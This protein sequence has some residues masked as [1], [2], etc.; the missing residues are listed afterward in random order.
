MRSEPPGRRGLDFWRPARHDRLVAC[1]PSELVALL[2]RFPAACCQAIAM[3]GSAR[4]CKSREQSAPPSWHGLQFPPR[5]AIHHQRPSTSAAVAA[6]LQH[7]VYE[8][9]L[10]PH[11]TPVVTRFSSRR[12]VSTNMSPSHPDQT[13]LRA[14]MSTCRLLQPARG[15]R[16]SPLTPSRRTSRHRASADHTPGRDGTEAFED[17]G[18]SDEAR[19]MLKKMYVGDFDGPVSTPTSSNS[20]PAASRN[21]MT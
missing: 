3:A 16:T 13:P 17:V 1:S 5:R 14:A 20:A 10:T 11:S 7:S 12:L 6:A 21:G 9:P 4:D 2:A 8:P 18:H 15:R 19:D